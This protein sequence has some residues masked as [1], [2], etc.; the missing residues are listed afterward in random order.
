MTRSGIANEYGIANVPNELQIENLIRIAWFLQ[1]LKD[2]LC[3]RFH[4]NVNIYV[5]SGFRCL[6]LNSHPK[7]KGSKYSKHMDGLA[8]DIVCSD[9]RPYQLATYIAKHMADTGY[10]KLINEFG[11]WVHVNLAEEEL[12]CLNMTATKINGKTSYLPNILNVA[13]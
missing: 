5:S 6:K 1:T 9:L 7:M 4:K 10:D 3:E 11:R 12:R 2:D 8:A 13:R